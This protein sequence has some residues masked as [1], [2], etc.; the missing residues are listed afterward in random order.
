VGVGYALIGGHAVNVWLEPRFTADVDLTIEADVDR[1]ELLEQALRTAGFALERS[2]GDAPS[3]PDFLSF[4]S[5]TGP[6][7]LELQVAKTAF[8]REV[9]RRATP[10]S[11]G[12][13]V[14]TSEDLIVPKLIANRARDQLD[15]LGLC[16]LPSIDWSYVERWARQ[17]DRTDELQRIRSQVR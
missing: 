1:I 6:M 17:W 3:G 12:L 10:R 5:T 11:E 2:Q 16:A 8:Q 14:A 9:I 15:L 13:R 4:R 7:V